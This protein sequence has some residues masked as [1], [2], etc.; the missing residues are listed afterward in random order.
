MES[1][2]REPDRVTGPGKQLGRLARPMRLNR[3][4][5]SC[6]GTGRR[7][8]PRRDAAQPGMGVLLP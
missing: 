5:W 4:I 7:S 1:M 6:R 3:F 8:L 2:H